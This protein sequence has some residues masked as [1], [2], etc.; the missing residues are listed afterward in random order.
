MAQ[1]I[2]KVEHVANIDLTYSVPVGKKI[3]GITGITAINVYVEINGI[4]SILLANNGSQ[5]ELY[6][7][8]PLD[9]AASSNLVFRGNATTTIAIIRDE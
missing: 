6:F 2:D 4:R 9:F 3:Y 5:R 7:P 1:V 8:V